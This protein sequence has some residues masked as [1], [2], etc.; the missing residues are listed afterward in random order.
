MPRPK[1]ALNITD[2]NHYAGKGA[3]D[4]SENGLDEG[5]PSTHMAGTAAAPAKT[6]RR[7]QLGLS[8]ARQDSNHYANAASSVR[9][10]DPPTSVD[11]NPVTITTCTS[12]SGAGCGDDEVATSAAPQLLLSSANMLDHEDVSSQLGG[13][14]DDPTH[15]KIGMA[16][17]TRHVSTSHTPRASGLGREFW[18][19]KQHIRGINR[20]T[21]SMKSLLRESGVSGSKRRGQ[22]GKGGKKI[23][24]LSI[25]ARSSVYAGLMPISDE[26][27]SSQRRHQSITA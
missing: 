7:P 2:S 27:S 26:R 5:S 20:G 13:P 6:K 19:S 18:S 22:G 25:A 23:N 16:R 10:D 4:D 21:M 17:N 9:S 11:A 12:V 3:A 24:R 14:A 1:L 8:I 15:T